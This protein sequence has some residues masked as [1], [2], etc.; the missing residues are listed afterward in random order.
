MRAVVISSFG[1]L[2]TVQD[3][4]APTCPDDGVVLRVTATGVCRS[5]W[6]GWQGHDDDIHLPHVPGHELAGVVTEVGPLVRSWAVGDAVTVPFVCAC[7]T[8]SACVAGEQ[9]VCERQR[10]PGFTDDGSFA[11]R[12][13]IHH[14]D[15]NLVRLPPGMSP[16]TAAGLGCR[17]ATAYRA[18]TV[19]GRAAAGEWVAVHGCGGVGL[20]AVM[21]AVAAG[22]RVVA[23]DVSLAARDAALAMGATAVLDG[24]G[25]V[26]ARVH[27]L[28]GGGAA[29]SLDALGSRAT[30]TASVLSLRRRGR[31]V[32]VGLLLGD[33][34]SPPLPMG[35]VIAWELEV[36][37]SHGM[38][39]HEYP[40]MLARIASGELD[41]S[42]LVGRTIGLDEA[43]AA[44]AA[45][46]DG[47]SGPGMTVVVL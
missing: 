17:F 8:C 2:P 18:V 15:V 21:V 36:Y 41:P 13:A 46:G 32:Q 44:L 4:P 9:Q 31:H 14:A 38:A 35:R 30:A 16:V 12:V 22:A 5:D 27:E 34:T 3:V 45:L 25:D 24:S 20:S 26:A 43:P 19:H 37:G 29:V 33:D 28:T 7:G 10:Q 6:H 39:A 11:E 47:S 40:A 23:V 1:V 42:R